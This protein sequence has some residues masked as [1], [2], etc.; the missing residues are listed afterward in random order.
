[1]SKEPKYCPY[2]GIMQFNFEIHGKIKRDVFE[3]KCEHCK[4]D[5]Y[6]ELNK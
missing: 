5:V 2:C 1:M 6:I 3:C 4:T